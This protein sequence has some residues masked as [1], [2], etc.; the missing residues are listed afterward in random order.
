[1]ISIHQCCGKSN[2]RRNES[3]LSRLTIGWNTVFV[4][5]LDGHTNCQC[6]EHRW[7]LRLQDAS[8]D[9]TSSSLSP[10][11]IFNH[12]NLEISHPGHH[13]KIIIRIGGFSC[14]TEQLDLFQI[15][16]INHVLGP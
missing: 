12:R 16:S 15:N 10:S 2:R 6:A 8:S 4:Q 3:H 11:T 5:E 9:V 7:N 1:M 13:P 14:G